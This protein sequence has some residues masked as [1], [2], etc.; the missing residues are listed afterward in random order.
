MEEDEASVLSMASVLPC[1]PWLYARTPSRCLSTPRT[2]L[3]TCSLQSDPSNPGPDME[4]QMCSCCFSGSRCHYLADQREI[5]TKM[6]A[7]LVDWLVEVGLGEGV[8][9]KKLGVALAQVHMKY[10]LKPVTL[11]MAVNIIDRYLSMRP[12]ACVYFTAGSRREGIGS[13]VYRPAENLP[14]S[15]KAGTI[16]PQVSRCCLWLPFLSL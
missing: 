6:R 8:R 11:F 1:Q 5:N 13:L 7:I 9:Q 2:S 3:T 16:F 4:L 12:V 15:V 10:R 14:G